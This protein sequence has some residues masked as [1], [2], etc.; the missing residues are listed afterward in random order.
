MITKLLPNF[1]NLH[2]PLPSNWLQVLSI[3]RQTN[4]MT[5]A[6]L[7]AIAFIAHCCSAIQSGNLPVAFRAPGSIT[8]LQDCRCFTTDVDLLMSAFSTT[9]LTN[10][11]SEP[12]NILH[13]SIESTIVPRRL[14]PKDYIK[15]VEFMHCLYRDANL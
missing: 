8:R 1:W 11:G 3:E 14:S 12:H 15:I 4:S 13:E 6:G 5:L 2:C 9:V 7:E 10:H